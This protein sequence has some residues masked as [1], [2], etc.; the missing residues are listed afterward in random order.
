M[1][2]IVSTAIGGEITDG[3]DG[4]MII[5]ALI[6]RM[7]KSLKKYFEEI[8]FESLG[9]IRI[10]I[11][12]SGKVSAYC[13]KTGITATRYSRAKKE[14]MAELCIDKHYWTS[15]PVLTIKRRFLLFMENSS[16]GLSEIIE[17]RLKAD[18]YDFDGN[19]FKEIVFKSLSEV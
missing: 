11:Y 3:V 13:D 15:E 10:K 8:F 12:V 1:E 17:K 4:E 5:H 18:G 16:V 19:L 14:Y 6:I 7:R 2:I 9:K